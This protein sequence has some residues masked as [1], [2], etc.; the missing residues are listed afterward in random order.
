[1]L[2]RI[3]GAGDSGQG[4]GSATSFLCVHV[5]VFI[6]FMVSIASVE[7][8][9]CARIGGMLMVMPERDLMIFKKKY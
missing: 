5:I 2:R 7:G 4:G 3:A 1:M 9:P 8:S 6:C